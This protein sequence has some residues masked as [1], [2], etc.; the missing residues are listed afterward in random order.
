V[1]R[2]P[3]RIRFVTDQCMYGMRCVM[4]SYLKKSS[5]C[6]RYKRRSL[7]LN[8]YDYQIRD[9]LVCVWNEV[10]GKLVLDDEYLVCKIQKTFLC[11]PMRIRFVID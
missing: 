7:A 4:D 8:T 6:E 2:I 9:R 5:Y 3:T 10:R 11:I 1:R